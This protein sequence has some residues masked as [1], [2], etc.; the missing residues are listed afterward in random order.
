M[1]SSQ[2]DIHI[3]EAKEH[4][5]FPNDPNR[6]G[7]KSGAPAQHAP[8]K[9]A[10]TCIFAATPRLSTASS[11]SLA[12]G[13]C[14]LL[15]ATSSTR[16]ELPLSSHC[17]PGNRSSIRTPPRIPASTSIAPLPN[18]D[19]GHFLRSREGSGSGHWRAPRGRCGGPGRP[20]EERRKTQYDPGGD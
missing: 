7:Q 8:A 17:Y 20:Q 3:L 18:T 6:S 2:K 1:F 13:A 4:L 16:S 14:S 9:R 11:H 15:A 19:G 10:A 12:H 5:N